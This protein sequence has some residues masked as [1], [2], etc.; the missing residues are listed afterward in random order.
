MWQLGGSGQIVGSGEKLTAQ[1][2]DLWGTD[3]LWGPLPPHISVLSLDRWE[4]SRNELFTSL[5]KGQ[6]T[7]ELIHLNSLFCLKLTSQPCPQPSADSPFQRQ[8]D[9]T[10]FNSSEGSLPW[11]VGSVQFSCSL[12]SDSAIPWT[13]AHQASLSITN[14]WSLLSSWTEGYILP[15]S[16]WNETSPSGAWWNGGWDWFFASPWAFHKLSKSS[17]PENQW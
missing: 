16:C 17:F 6:Q 10:G 12:V 2:W 8:A 13:A 5:F 1:F 11:T 15:N 14:T 9:S 7:L 3:N 4:D